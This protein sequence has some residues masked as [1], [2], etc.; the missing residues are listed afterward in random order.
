MIISHLFA[1]SYIQ[2]QD[3]IMNTQNQTSNVIDFLK[4]NGHILTKLLNKADKDILAT[5]TEKNR[6]VTIKMLKGDGGSKTD[7]TNYL[8]V[9][10]KTI[11]YLEDKSDTESRQI[12]KFKQK[13]YK[14]I[15]Q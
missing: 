2:T 7:P 11:K 6:D 9:V 4:S 10:H 12:K 8:K 5:I 13:L 15:N 3:I 1:I 14:A